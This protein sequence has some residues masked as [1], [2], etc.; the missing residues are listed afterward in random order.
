MTPLDITP[1]DG[2]GKY[3]VNVVINGRRYCKPCFN[4]RGFNYN[5]M[6]HIEE[7]RSHFEAL[8]WKF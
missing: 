5:M 6:D 3:D 7:N 4:E 2:C 1:C 8:G